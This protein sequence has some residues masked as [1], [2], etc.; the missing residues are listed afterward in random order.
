MGTV[1][2]TEAVVEPLVPTAKETFVGAPGAELLLPPPPHADS[3]VET[4]MQT[5]I[6][7]R[8]IIFFIDLTFIDIEVWESRRAHT[9]SASDA[10]EQ[11]RTHALCCIR[12]SNKAPAKSSKYWRSPRIGTLP[13]AENAGH[14][15]SAARCNPLQGIG[16]GQSFRIGG[17]RW[18]MRQCT[19][20][21]AMA[22]RVVGLRRRRFI[23]IC[24]RNGGRHS[25]R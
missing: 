2:L 19:A 12:R 6:V 3:S 10:P 7:R 23:S 17:K 9:L 16:D 4:R 8:L 22:H 5:P 15:Q 13:N 25:L 11:L 24:T 20:V 21:S 14:L 1:K 18:H